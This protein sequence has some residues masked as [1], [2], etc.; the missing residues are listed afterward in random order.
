MRPIALLTDF[1]TRDWFTGAMKGAAL[2]VAPR[3][4]TVDITHEIEPGDITS[5][6]FVLARC[7]D[8]FPRNCVFVVVVDPGVGTAR[9]ALAA[10]AG[11]RLFVGPDNGVLC[12]V[13]DSG[14]RRAVHEVTNTALFRTEVS[15]TFHGRD[16]FAP[17]GAHLAKGIPL[18]S[19]GPAIRDYVRL[20]LP[21][22][23]VAGDKIH[24][25]VVYIDRF[26]NAITT[27]PGGEIDPRQR[28]HYAVVVGRRRRVPV[29]LCFGDVPVG[30]AVAITGSSGYLEV[31]INGGNAASK[32]A[33]SIGS[34]VTLVRPSR[35]RP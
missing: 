7:V 18:R 1:G 29:G 4:T 5:A 26:G 2:Q 3:V 9:R 19:V 21:E 20:V 35:S 10:R 34:P 30:K 27:I 8:T 33:L 14:S 31:S 17:V 16:I 15:S 23:T 11:G 25:E 32:M 6:A 24:G 12:P 22:A 13:L 28:R